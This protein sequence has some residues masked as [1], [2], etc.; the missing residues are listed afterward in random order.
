MKNVQFFLV[1][2]C[3][4]FVNTAFAGGHEGEGELSEMVLKVEAIKGSKKEAAKIQKKLE[5]IDGVKSVY[6]CTCSG[7]VKLTYNTAEMGCHSKVTTALDG[8]WKYEMVSNTAAP[9]SCTGE[10][11]AS[12]C[13]KSCPKAGSKKAS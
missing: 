10:K 5:K 3:F 12:D 13:T 9:K 2:V 7:T 6:A 1:A 4:L 8:K 11:K